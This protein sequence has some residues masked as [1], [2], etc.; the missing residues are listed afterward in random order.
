M[1]LS[2]TQANLTNP[3]FR[4]AVESRTSL[5]EEDEDD[6]THAPHADQRAQLPQGVEGVSDFWTLVL[7]C[8]ESAR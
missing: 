4:V 6:F 7:R 8:R 3:A 1:H 5:V 2:I